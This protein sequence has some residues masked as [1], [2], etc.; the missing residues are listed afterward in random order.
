M[1]PADYQAW[2]SGGA[3]GETLAVGRGQALRAAARCNT[4]HG[5]Q[6]GAAARAGRA[7]RQTGPACRTAQTVVADEAYIRESII[8]PAGQARR[9]LPADHAHVP[10]ADQRG[11]PAAADRIH[12]VPAPRRPPAPAAE[13]AASGRRASRR[14]PEQEAARSHEHQAA[15]TPTRRPPSAAR[16]TT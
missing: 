12:Q 6:T 11:G 3:P 1:K 4:C 16:R 14:P 9:G 13:P 10:G 7:L 2:L 5:E 8:E 15:A